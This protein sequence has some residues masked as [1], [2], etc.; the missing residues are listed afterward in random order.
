MESGGQCGVGV[1][2]CLM[3][4][5]TMNGGGRLQPIHN[6]QQPPESNPCRLGGRSIERLIDRSTS[7]IS[8]PVPQRIESTTDID[9]IGIGPRPI[10]PIASH[11]IIPSQRMDTHSPT[12]FAG[13]SDLKLS[14]SLLTGCDLARNQ[15][16]E[17]ATNVD[18][19]LICIA[20]FASTHFRSFLS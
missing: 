20:R 11:P 5:M 9:R 18:D 6:R 7:S 14:G 2:R 15:Q 17:E 4:G 8:Q 3:H 1:R 12:I 10:H 19:H 13:P 16:E